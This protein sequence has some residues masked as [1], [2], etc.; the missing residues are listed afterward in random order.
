[1]FLKHAKR[2]GIENVRVMVKGFGSGRLV[3]TVKKLISL[4]ILK[5]MII[6]IK[7][8]KGEHKSVATRQAQYRLDHGPNTHTHAICQA[9]K[10][11]C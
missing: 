7:T 11:A 3:G 5:N 8:E 4:S 6:L 2:R 10:A 9:T 1:M